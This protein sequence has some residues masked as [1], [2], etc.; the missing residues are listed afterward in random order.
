MGM[1]SLA[2]HFFFILPSRVFQPPCC[3]RSLLAQCP[4]VVKFQQNPDYSSVSRRHVTFPS[5][6]KINLFFTTVHCF[7]NKGPINTKHSYILACNTVQDI[8]V[9]SAINDCDKPWTSCAWLLSAI[10]NRFTRLLIFVMPLPPPFLDAVWCTWTQRTWA[11]IPSGRN[12]ATAAA[13]IRKE[14]NWTDCLR[15]MF[16]LVSIW[17]SRA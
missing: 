3:V 10:F 16:H 12:G 14:R 8:K 11:L 9:L 6:C 13:A 5:C 2:Q 7:G 17:S 4:S 1:Q 15:N